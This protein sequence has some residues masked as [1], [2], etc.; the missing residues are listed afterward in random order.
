MRWLSAVAEEPVPFGGGLLYG[1]VLHIG[2]DP[3]W[4][5]QLVPAVS[6]D[7]VLPS[8][9]IGRRAALAGR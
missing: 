2:E 4:V 3:V 8:G 7:C 1:V 5:L 9:E 6:A